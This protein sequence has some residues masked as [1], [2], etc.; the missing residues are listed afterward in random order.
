MLMTPTPVFNSLLR[1]EGASEDLPSPYEKPNDAL[2][3]WVYELPTHH[4]D[5]KEWCVKISEILSAQKDLL[6][7]M[8]DMGCDI[9]L[10]IEHS[11]ELSVLNLQHGFLNLLAEK[12]ISLEISKSQ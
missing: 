3:V 5:I 6:H 12:G 9:T 1:V 10:F 7:W 8:R 2:G 11:A 4:Q